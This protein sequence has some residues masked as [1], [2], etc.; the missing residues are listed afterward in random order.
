M[1]PLIAPGVHGS[2]LMTWG[3]IEG[4]PAVL[5]ALPVRNM[6]TPSFELQETSRREKL[7]NRL[8]S[9]AVRTYH[10]QFGAPSQSRLKDARN[11]DPIEKATR[12]RSNVSIAQCSCPRFQHSVNPSGIRCAIEGKLFYTFAA[13]ASFFQDTEKIR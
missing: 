12:I 9:E 6:Q 3:E 10:T 1:T 11:Q 7:A 2:P 8:E 13:T 4:T 5:G